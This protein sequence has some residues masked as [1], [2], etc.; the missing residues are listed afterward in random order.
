MASFPVKVCFCTDE[1]EHDCDY[2]SKE[3]RVKKGE[4]FNIFVVAVDQ[5]NSFVAANIISSVASKDG[6]LS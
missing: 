2:Q 3:I 5:V 4:S 1:G 6:S